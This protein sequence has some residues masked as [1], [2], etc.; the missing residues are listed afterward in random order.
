MSKIGKIYKGSQL[1]RLASFVQKVPRLYRDKN[2]LIE[3]LEIG[4]YNFSHAPNKGEYKLVSNP[5]RKKEI[6]EKLILQIEED[7]KNPDYSTISI[8]SFEDKNKPGYYDRK[9][10]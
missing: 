7:K 3:V 1:E 9:L 5:K 4:C 10:K 6:E 2:L 8:S